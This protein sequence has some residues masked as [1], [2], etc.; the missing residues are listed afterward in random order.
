MAVGI[1]R[2]PVKGKLICEY[3]SSEFNGIYLC[4]SQPLP[5]DFIAEHPGVVIIINDKKQISKTMLGLGH[6][7]QL[8][9][10]LS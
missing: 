4:S 7:A 8:V 6:A 5:Y 10:A 3:I 1:L 9:G 2:E